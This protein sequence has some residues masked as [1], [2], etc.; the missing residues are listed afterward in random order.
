MTTQENKYFIPEKNEL[1]VGYQCEILKNDTP[2]NRWKEHT[3]YPENYFDLSNSIISIRTKYFDRQ[4]IES[5]GWIRDTTK[6]GGR[7]QNYR[8]GLHWILN[9]F[10]AARVEGE[11]IT[12]MCPFITMTLDYAPHVIFRGFCRSINEFKRI[13]DYL[14]IY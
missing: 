2:S 13:I 12:E 14:N 10:T 8:L 3:W 5:L 11:L 4:G 1:F 7:G 9:F 6:T